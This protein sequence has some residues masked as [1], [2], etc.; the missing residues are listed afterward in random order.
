MG[1]GQRDDGLDGSSR[2]ANQF[3][4]VP[5]TTHHTLVVDPMLPQ[6]VERFLGTE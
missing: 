4:F 3:A 6:I 2:P 1:G 5:N